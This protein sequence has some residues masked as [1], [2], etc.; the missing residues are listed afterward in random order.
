LKP[1]SV[2]GGW[3]GTLLANLYSSERTFTEGGDP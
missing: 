2:A 1:R 3:S